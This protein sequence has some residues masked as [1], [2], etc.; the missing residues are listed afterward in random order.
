MNKKK[1][2]KYKKH[3]F[4]VARKSLKRKRFKQTLRF[5]HHVTPYAIKYHGIGGISKISPYNSQKIVQVLEYDALFDDLCKPSIEELL[6]TV[7]RERAIKIACLLDNLY[8]EAEIKDLNIFFAS[9]S[10]KNRQIIIG[11]LRHFENNRLA[12]LK[13]YWTTNETSA[14]LLRIVFAMPYKSVVDD[15]VSNEETEMRIFKSILLINQKAME[16][17]IKK[18]D[19]NYENLL[20]LNSTMNTNMQLMR[21]DERKSRTIMQIYFAVEF[22]KFLTS[23]QK[24]QSL[25][26]AFLAEHKSTNWQEYIRSVFGI[27]IA[28]NYKSGFIDK[29]LKNDVDHLINKD[30]LESLSIPFNKEIKYESTSAFDRDGNTDYKSFRNKPIIKMHN[31]DY[32]I[33]NWE[34]MIDRLF[35]ALYFEFKEL[36]VSAKLSKLVPSIFTEKFAEKFL[37]DRLLED[38]IDNSMYKMI[39]EDDMKKVYN[40]AQNELGPPDYMLE[41]KDAYVL[42][43]CKDIRIGGAEIESHDFERIFDVY[44]NKLNRKRWK[45]DENGQVIDL[46]NNGRNKGKR[47]GI[48]Q[49]TYH[50]SRIRNSSFNYYTT[51]KDKKIYPV[52]ILSDY[53]YVHRGF[54]N[55]ANKWYKDDLGIQYKPLLDRPLIIM[56]FI[57]LIKYKELFKINGFEYYFECYYNAINKPCISH[58][59]AM[60]VNQSFDDYMSNYPFNLSK[61]SNE[62]INII[63]YDR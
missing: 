51:E 55:I 8:K 20:F 37:F 13:V 49:I 44:S 15:S 27:V 5:R 26:N 41:K 2:W 33:Y 7:S 29:E 46:T 59:T 21:E 3:Q 23:K 56:S 61:F 39:S 63:R 36:P 10:I 30:I 42:F 14:Q 35:N 12:K 4:Y 16:H 18:K 6:S 54:T 17:N 47:I 60:D 43:E 1:E 9:N 32:C 48:T 58:D 52:L 40:P 62:L 50:I 53:K 11:R 25:Y 45:Y 22:F 57:T 19:S 38:S 31:G 34:I 24:Y 28:M